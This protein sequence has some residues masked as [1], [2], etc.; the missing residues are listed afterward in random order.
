MLFDALEK[1]LKHTSGENLIKSLYEGN[2]AYQTQCLNC[3][4]VREKEEK[5]FDL[6][7]QVTSMCDVADSLRNYTAPELLDGRNKYEC[8]ICGDKQPAHRRVAIKSVPPILSLSCQRFDIDRTTW[9]RVKVISKFEFP[10]VLDM[11]LCVS[12]HNNASEVLSSPVSEDPAVEQERTNI[13]RDRM[14]F[15]DVVLQTA[16]REAERL[17]CQYGSEFS[18]S[19]VLA[20]PEEYQ[21][22]RQQ[23]KFW[24]ASPN[25][26]SDSIYELFAVIMHGGTAYSGHYT[27]YIRDTFHEGAW[28]TPE[29]KSTGS[30]S[31]SKARKGKAREVLCAVLTPKGHYVI[32]E[33]SPLCVVLTIVQMELNTG[34]EKYMPISKLSSCIK[35]NLGKTWSDMY[36]ADHGTLTAFIRRHGMFF[37]VDGSAKG[38]KIGLKDIKYQVVSAEIYEKA[39]RESEVKEGGG[40]GAGETV[41]TA[42]TQMESQLADDLALALSL[43]SENIEEE[44]K[45]SEDVEEEAG[46]S[47]WEDVGEKKNKKKSR[48]QLN[49]EGAKAAARKNNRIKTQHTATSISKDIEQKEKDAT[50]NEEVNSEVQAQDRLLASITN[51]LVNEFYGPFFSFNDSIVQPIELSTL[52]D[53]FDGRT[54]AYIL[55]Y[56][57]AGN[58]SSSPLVAVNPP[59]VYSDAVQ[60]MN[61]ELALSRESYDR[62]ASC[63][64]LN[65]FFSKDLLVEWPLVRIASSSGKGMEVEVDI[66]GD[67]ECLI[68]AIVKR[69]QELSVTPYLHKDTLVV[70]K[71]ETYGG[72]FFL[73]HPFSA[74]DTIASTLTNHTQIYVITKSDLEKS[75]FQPL[76]APPRRL[77]ITMDKVGSKD[78][79]EKLELTIP[80]S[81]NLGELVD[82]VSRYAAASVS[83]FVLYL[84]RHK[85]LSAR[86]SGKQYE[87]T[88]SVL[89]KNSEVAKPFS[90]AATYDGIDGTEIIVEML[91]GQ[92]PS[93][94]NLADR[95]VARR[96]RLWCVTVDLDYTGNLNNILR[97]YAIGGL[98][99]PCAA[100]EEGKSDAAIPADAIVRTFSSI[101]TSVKVR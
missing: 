12:G 60:K 66:R 15:L 3:S 96:N 47:G 75:Q 81:T 29:E 90:A 94:T 77:A 95:E 71:L 39:G 10:L 68:S 74:C 25:E 53:A 70:G 35:D 91:N 54:S 23:L 59:A 67:V 30:G 76:Y 14:I 45:A 100:V 55:I 65:V 58:C 64:R 9:Q 5:Y 18:V 89:W 49:K 7:L 8:D 1:S 83:E 21:Y 88:Y 101:D 72:S 62:L 38:I 11:S 43:E 31:G 34:T 63:Y 99:Y 27:A 86:K 79:L 26:E 46:G 52:I 48:R 73:R 16:K 97:D 2:L 93:S 36:Q 20:I 22:L 78:E 33:T 6:L 92:K 84:I 56:R 69:S 37:A 50:E 98:H 85:Q 51:S 41:E 28:F 19:D 82:L 57:K 32:D 87:Y 17:I 80:S 13:L 42:E 44:L 24:N 40:H 61:S 4:V